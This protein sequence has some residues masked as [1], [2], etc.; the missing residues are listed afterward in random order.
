MLARWIRTFPG[1]LEMDALAPG[2]DAQ[3]IREELELVRQMTDYLR[4]DGVVQF[5]E[6]G[7]IR[8]ALSNSFKDGYILEREEVLEVRYYLNSHLA[9]LREFNANA[10][11]YPLLQAF[12]R[13]DDFPY[14]L[15]KRLSVLFEDNGEISD[16]ASEELKRIRRRKQSIR[17]DIQDRLKRLMEDEN[18]VAALQER[19]VTVREGRFVIPVKNQNRSRVKS[20]V[21][22]FS[23]S[24]ETAYVE[25]M[26]VV[27]LNNE[28]V[29]IDGLE[30]AELRRILREVTREIG[31]CSENLGELF[32]RIGRIEMLAAKARFSIEW[33]CRPP[34]ITDERSYVRLFRARHP[35][36][37]KDCVP[38]QLE[39]G[40]TFDGLVISG[41]NAGGKTVA[42]K[43]TGL[44]ILMAQSGIPIPAD[45]R[46]E[47][48]IFENVLSEIGD[49]Q[50]IAENLSS[51]SG[52]I[53]SISGILSHCNIRTL[54]LIDEILSSTSP[55]EGEALGREI[56]RE[57]LRR[58]GKFVIT[59]H[60][61]A[62]KEIAYH[63]ERVR[64]AYMEF[65]EEKLR[66]LF[67]LHPDGTGS[68][69]ALK[70][71]R[72]Y[73]LDDDVVS[74]AEAWLESRAS[75]TEKI[76]RNL[77]IERAELNRKR[78]TV[79]RHLDEARKIRESFE[80]KKI[81]LDEALKTG[82]KKT[83]TKLQRELDD[84]LREIAELRGELR[85]KQMETREK[86]KSAD[87]AVKS[88]S[89]VLEGSRREIAGRE[90][91]K[92]EALQPGDRV[93]VSRF[94]KEGIVE[95]VHDGKAKVRVG[96]F[97]LVVGM[98]E[99]FQ[100]DRTERSTPSY[101]VQTASVSSAPY[102]LDLR[103][104]RAE[105]ALHEVEKAVESALVGGASILHIIHGKGEG[106]LRKAIWDYLK[107][108]PGVSSWDFAR[109]EDGGQ[110][111]TIVH[112]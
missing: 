17:G 67:V 24:G 102:Q 53:R 39:V 42:L 87:K 45:A 88:A 10:A 2:T 81:E 100:T 58:G 79:A 66:P 93:Y 90:R 41:P 16:N 3:A 78:E 112:F 103:G 34:L 36:I 19:I 33:D 37:G 22:S 43:T 108:A 64:N 50:S 52:H 25:P 44:L 72:K 23:K 12:F 86:L 56:C 73:D 30:L 38:V 85:K 104:Y 5:D 69:Y 18:V 75:D 21:H 28:I 68:S 4:F 95:A 92:A 101:S 54:V 59:T 29:E 106:I 82:E 89:D 60:Y 46:S 40:D 111:K 61:Q 20:I 26:E 11:K 1:I 48:G 77:E 70:I 32:L 107:D 109:P 74:R 91:K 57:I 49:E 99:L 51:F 62:I 14:P 98:E 96:I 71:A 47:I 55:N 15:Q 6:M 76:V 80:K 35:L 110:G 65:D 94:E 97:S 9:N 105:E 27:S 13:D 8:E 84:A 83:V 7:D 63:E 31:V